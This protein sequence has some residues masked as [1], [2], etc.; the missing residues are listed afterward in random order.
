MV[1][2]PGHHLGACISCARV[3]CV[4]RA[5]VSRQMHTSEFLLRPAAL[6]VGFLRDSELLKCLSY[7]WGIT[8][9]VHVLRNLNM[10]LVQFVI[11][12]DGTEST[13]DRSYTF[14]IRN[15]AQVYRR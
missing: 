9:V 4:W 10:C 8:N 11:C 6:T 13:L 15:A 7:D 2:A 3:A 12:L 14:V 1:R 5:H